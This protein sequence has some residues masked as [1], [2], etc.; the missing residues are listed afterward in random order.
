M[1]KSVLMSVFAAILASTMAT[2]TNYWV[3]T[4]VDN[5][6]DSALDFFNEESWSE[7]LNL[8]DDNV[9]LRFNVSEID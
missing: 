2:V 8:D 4:T 5:S 3:N 7:S 6:P 1:K 9:F